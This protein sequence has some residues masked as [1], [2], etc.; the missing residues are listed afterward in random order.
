MKISKNLR[1]FVLTALAAVTSIA[2]AAD[3]G[4]WVMTSSGCSVYASGEV[5]KSLTVSWTGTCSDGFADGKGVLTWSNG[6]RYEGDLYVG[7]MSGKG[8]FYWA[9]GDWYS[10][11]FKNGSREGVGTQYLGCLGTYHGEFHRGVMDGIGVF[12]LVSGDR[13]QGMFHNGEMEGLGIRSFADGGEYEGQFRR[14][15]QEGLGTLVLAN[16]SH[17]EGEFSNSLP[18]GHALVTYPDG[19]IFEGMYVEGHADGRGILTKPNG[20]RDV[21]TFKDTKGVLK[22]I[23]NIGPQ[24]YEPC[25]SHCSTTTTSCGGNA[26]A[27]IS[28]DDPNYQMKIMDATVTCG[29][30]MQ[31]CVTMCALHNP[32]ARELKGVVEI[33][34]VDGKESSPSESDASRQAKAAEG[35]AAINFVDE[36]V[37][38][39]ND[40]R[41]RLTRMDHDLQSLRQKLTEIPIESASVAALPRKSDSEC[42][43]LVHH[44][45]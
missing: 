37:A 1:V 4:S 36:Q 14:G 44:S 3:N 11:E 12:D 6:N 23:S 25:Q 40:L 28:P 33:G 8:T 34:E 7:M 42:R 16:T 15:Q 41:N 10:G 35:K 31:Q 24:L 26:A 21:G 19:D 5:P 38:S 20:E 22:L 45:K 18:E 2:H 13:Y 39:T 30:E 17:Y 43:S 29:R 32:T 9:N 27:G